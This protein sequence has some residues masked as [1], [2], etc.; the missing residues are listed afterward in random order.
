MM[1]GMKAIM[2]KGYHPEL[3]GLSAFTH[4]SPPLTQLKSPD[5]STQFHPSLPDVPEAY[6]SEEGSDST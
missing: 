5:P 1:K 4:S 2:T 6:H 3:K